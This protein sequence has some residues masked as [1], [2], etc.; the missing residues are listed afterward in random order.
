MF[1][2]FRKKSS[3]KNDTMED[4]AATQAELEVEVEADVVSSGDEIEQARQDL[5]RAA[6]EAIAIPAPE[7]RSETAAS[8]PSVTYEADIPVIQ[9]KVT[10]PVAPIPAPQPKPPAPTQTAEPTTKMEP[11]SSFEPA[12]SPLSPVESTIDEQKTSESVEEE[13]TAEETSEIVPLRTEPL[14]VE[15]FPVEQELPPEDSIEEPQIEEQEDIPE[16]EIIAQIAPENELLSS[17]FMV[18]ADAINTGAPR[19]NPPAEIPSESPPSEILSAPV[20]FPARP[21]ELPDEPRVAQ[22]DDIMIEIVKQDIA[23]RRKRISPPN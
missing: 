11:V 5:M 6:M 15:A 1:G 20:S 18:F 3:L 22:L 13:T 21:G 14:V 8:V 19:E 12:A 16:D 4:V 9:V 10:P 7:V 23:S 17:R 2:R